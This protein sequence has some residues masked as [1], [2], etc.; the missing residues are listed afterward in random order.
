LSV[1]L[2]STGSQK[3]ILRVHYFEGGGFTGCIAKLGKA[4]AFL[5]GPHALVKQGKLIA[6]GGSFGI[7]LFEV[8]DETPLCCRKGYLGY[9]A[10]NLALLDFLL[11]LK[12]VPD[13]DIECAANRIAQVSDIA[14]AP[15]CELWSI[16][17]VAKIQRKVGQ[18]SCLG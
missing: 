4:Q 8:G 17:T 15:L 14:R 18:I 9:V 3:G 2:R 13:R 11:R 6:S 10:L 7:D 1:G 5:C 12:P 16:D